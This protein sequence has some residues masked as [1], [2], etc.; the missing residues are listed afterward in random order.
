MVHS[1]LLSL[2]ICNVLLHQWEILLS[3]STK[4]WTFKFWLGF[5]DGSA[6]K[7]FPCNAGDTDVGL[8]PGSGRS[9]GEGNGSPVFLPEKSHGQR[10]LAGYSPKGRK[11]SDTTERLTLY[12]K[13]SWWG[14]CYIRSENFTEACEVFHLGLWPL[15]ICQSWSF[16]SEFPDK[17]LL[18]SC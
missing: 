14:F 13:L 4:Q 6:G 8:I 11:E 10:S 9:L 2:L 1:S 3:Q 16:E 7:E 17:L 15:S 12:C 18:F 5:A